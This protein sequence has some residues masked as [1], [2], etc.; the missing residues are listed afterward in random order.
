MGQSLRRQKSHRSYMA[1]QNLFCLFGKVG[2]FIHVFPNV[3]AVL[4]LVSQPVGGGIVL[5]EPVTVVFEFHASFEQMA[6]RGQGNLGNLRGEI[7]F[8]HGVVDY[9]M[10]TFLPEP[11][12]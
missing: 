4:L 11:V 3:V 10:S 12:T 2:L 6:F 7:V 5:V 8:F 1:F 9:L